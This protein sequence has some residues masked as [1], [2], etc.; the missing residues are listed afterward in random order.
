M[1]SVIRKRTRQISLGESDGGYHSF[2]SE[3]AF[4]GHGLLEMAERPAV[5]LLN[6]SKLPSETL[7]LVITGHPVCVTLP[8]FLLHEV[9][10]FI[11][12]PVPKTHVMTGVSLAFK[13]QWGC[14]PSAMRLQ[15]HPDFD[16]KI[17][18]I[19]R[20]LNPQLVV[21]DGTYFLD[22]A[23]P[24]TGDAVKMDLLIAGDGPGTASAVACRVMGINPDSIA[25]HRVAKREG[26]FPNDLEEVEINTRPDPFC[27]RKFKMRRAFLDWISLAGFHNRTLSRIFWEMPSAGPLHALL[28]AIRRNPWIGRLLYGK[29]GPPPDS[30]PNTGT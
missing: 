5:C 23:G 4:R 19:N 15:E 1:I 18:A 12:L 29:A 10:V 7:E 20:V 30:R 9:D 24:M 14:I 2:C 27:R 21:F 16:R 6:L 17:V 8:R 22:G 28:Y 11:T 3:D 25:H 13:N 26:L